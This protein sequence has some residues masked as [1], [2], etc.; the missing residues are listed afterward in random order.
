MLRIQKDVD[1]CDRSTRFY[2]QKDNLEQLRR[3][4]TT[5]IYR[6]LRRD[7]EDG[8]VQGM[9]DLIAPLLVVLGGE[10]LTLACFERLMGRMRRNFPQSTHNNGMEENLNNFVRSPTHLIT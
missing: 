1:R 7:P 2:A 9:C 3:V 5:Y 6:R 8:Y 4:I 10:A